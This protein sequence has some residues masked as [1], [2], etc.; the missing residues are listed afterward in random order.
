MATTRRCEMST[1][2]LPAASLSSA[3]R[4]P[5]ARTLFW[6]SNYLICT[7]LWSIG[8]AVFRIASSFLRVLRERRVPAL[9]RSIVR[10]AG[11]DPAFAGRGLLALPERRFGLQP[12]DQEM[13]GGECRLA[14]ADAQ[15]SIPTFLRSIRSKSI[16]APRP[17][18]V[19]A[20]T[21]P[22][23]STVMSSTRPYFCIASG[24]STSKNSVFRIAMIT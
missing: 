9:P 7:A 23:R 17:G 18:S 6:A 15:L 14:V 21:K 24:N 3:R 10:G 4:L 2:I 1:Q 20:W 5:A 11:F 19:G 22:S 16:L 8:R 12:V 13:A